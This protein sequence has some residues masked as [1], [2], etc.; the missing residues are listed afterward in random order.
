PVR[1]PEDPYASSIE[2]A[3]RAR[4]LAHP[5]AR[6]LSEVFSTLWEGVPGIGGQSIESLGL[7]PLDKVS[8]ISDVV[9]AQ[10][11]SQVSKALGNRKASLYVS[12]QAGAPGLRVLVPAPPAIVASQQLIS[13]DPSELRFLI[14]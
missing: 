7:T 3:D 12:P 8:P 9:I 14:G 1:K 2:E 11:F 4:Y 13:S 6:V 5:E 10:I